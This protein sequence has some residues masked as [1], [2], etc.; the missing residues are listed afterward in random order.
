MAMIKFKTSV[1]RRAVELFK[2]E[3]LNRKSTIKQ[4]DSENNIIESSTPDVQKISENVFYEATEIV[5]MI[6]SLCVL[7]DKKGSYEIFLTASEIK[8]LGYENLL[9]GYKQTRSLMGE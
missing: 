6:D 9:D 8:I 5:E 7:S 1:V 2:T 3:I 4:L